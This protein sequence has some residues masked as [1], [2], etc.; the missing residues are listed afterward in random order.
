M[1]TEKRRFIKRCIAASIT[2][3]LISSV[4]S[5]CASHTGTKAVTAPP[6]VKSSVNQEN[7]RILSGGFPLSETPV[8]LKMA[9]MR[10]T[11]LGDWN[12]MLVFKEYEKITNVKVVFDAIAEDCYRERLNVMLASNDL[13]DAFLKGNLEPMDVAEY[14]ANESLIPMEK[15]IEY[16]APNIKNL[17]DKYPEVKSSCY[18]VN[19]HIY[20]LPVVVTLDSARTEKHWINK[21]WLRKIRAEIPV[22]LEELKTVLWAFKNND[23]NGNGKPDEIPMTG[24]GI[25]QIIDNF[26]GAFG[27]QIQMGYYLNID[28][29]RVR[30]WLNSDRYRMLLQYLADLYAEGLLDK[31]IF[32]SNYDIFYPKIRPDRVGVF[33]NQTDDIFSMY[34]EDFIGI[35]PW[36]GPLGDQ[37]KNQRSIAR[38]FGAFAITSA[39]K[40]PEITM[41]WIDYFYGE[42]GSFFLRMGIEGETYT[43]KP[44]GTYDYVDSVKNCK[45]G[46]AYA[47]GKFTIW[48]GMGAPHWINDNNSIGV[49]SKNT[50]EAQA[51]LKDYLVQRVSNRPILDIKSEKRLNELK[52]N[53]DLFVGASREKFIKGEFGFSQWDTYCST[54][55]RLGIKEIQ[56][57]YQRA[58][59]LMDK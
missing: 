55:D 46:L 29:G 41:K 52:T 20:S 32:C 49:N 25:Q 10:T 26:T 21:K 1:G 13:P 58:Y 34:S 28:D 42:E 12:N 50:Q 5:G 57:I 9:G 6:A 47:V 4:Y 54:L 51:A 53:I 56:D 40:Y 31:D 37:I 24:T 17:I 44:D 7:G 19:G 48:P 15:L 43:R 23:M 35:A 3:L 30:L 14:S 39:N 27:L 22:T 18:S 33:H 11:V 8:T 2:A 45:N 38:D 16:C 36:K 59:D